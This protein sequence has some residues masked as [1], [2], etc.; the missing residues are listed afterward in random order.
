MTLNLARTGVRFFCAALTA[1]APLISRAEPLTREQGDAILEELRQIRGLLERE[2]KA[3][4]MAAPQQGSPARVNVSIKG[5]HALGQADA[6]VT[7][8]AFVDYQCPFCKR[9]DVQTWPELKK[10]YVDR[11]K[12]RYVVRDLPLDEI[13]PL[14]R[15]AS[16]ATHCAGDQGKYWQMRDKLVVNSERL[17]LEAL[18]GYARD[19]G[20]KVDTFKTCVERG[21]H[22][23]TVQRTAAIARDLGIGGTPTFVIGKSSGDIVT[24]VRLVGAQPFAVFDQQIKELLNSR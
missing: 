21:R 17:D 3:P 19:L 2:L 12:L 24:G 1:L 15:K 10:Q 6:P 4:A 20:L 9:F 8:V 5:A 7:M 18:T 23:E 14:A 16:E 22:A 13:H 11:G